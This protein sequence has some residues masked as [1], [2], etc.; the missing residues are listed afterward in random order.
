MVRGAQ[1]C[2]GACCSAHL[3]N[4]K[5]ALGHRND[6]RRSF[7]N[8]FALPSAACENKSR[9]LACAATTGGGRACVDGSNGWAFFLDRLKSNRKRRGGEWSA[10][11]GDGK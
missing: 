9:S 8:A 10:A 1:D 11:V 3:S 2:V 4:N 7:H 5:G 6:Q